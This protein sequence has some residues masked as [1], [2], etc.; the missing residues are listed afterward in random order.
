MVSRT[1]EWQGEHGRK[2]GFG[3][4]EDKGCVVDGWVDYFPESY[5]MLAYPSNPRGIWSSKTS[6]VI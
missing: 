4:L 6:M 2:T 3:T 1:D 5:I